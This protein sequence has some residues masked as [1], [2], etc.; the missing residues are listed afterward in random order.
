MPSLERSDST[1]K[2]WRSLNELEQTPEFQELVKE[3]FPAGPEQ[4]WTEPSRRRFLQL[5][6]ASLALGTASSCR[7]G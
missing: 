3:E 5:M 7:A 1:R 6:G 2:Y 4:E